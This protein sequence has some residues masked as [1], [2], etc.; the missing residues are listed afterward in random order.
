ML[1]KYGFM[2]EPLFFFP[3][4]VLKYLPGFYFIFPDFWPIFYSH[5]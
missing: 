4:N 2:F 3:F 5:F 1:L